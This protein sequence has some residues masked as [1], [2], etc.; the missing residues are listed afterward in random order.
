[1]TPDLNVDPSRLGTHDT[2]IFVRAKNDNC[3]GSYDIGELDYDSLMVW[4]KSRGGS[5]PW[6]ENC[7]CVMLGHNGSLNEEP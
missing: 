3:W 7:V 2:G 6:A 1:M 4:L 5:N